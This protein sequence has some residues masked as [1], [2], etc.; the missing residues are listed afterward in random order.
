MG[1]RSL[2]T[3]NLGFII[4]RKAEIHPKRIAI[5]DLTKGETY[6]YHQ[7]KERSDLCACYLLA[8]GLKRGDTV[9]GLLANRIECFDLMFACAKVGGIFIPLNFRMS[10]REVNQILSKAKSPVLFYDG[11]FRERI[12]EI[13]CRNRKVI[14]ID[15]TDLRTNIPEKPVYDYGKAEDPFVLIYTSGTSGEPKGAIQ[16]HLNAFFKSVDSIIDFGM[17]YNDVVLV[18]APMF[19]VAGLNALTLPGLHVGGR[20]VLHGRFEAEQALQIIEDEQVTCFA[21]VPTILRMMANAPSFPKRKFRSLRFAM[22]GG[23]FLE[24]ELQQAF[25]EKGADILN[26]FGLSETTDG[27]IY[28]R[29]GRPPIEACIGNVGTHVDVKLMS[30]DFQEVP[31]GETGEIVVGGPTVSPGYWKDPRRTK[32]T[33]RNGWVRTGDLAY[34]DKEGYFYTVGRQDEMIK[35]GAEKIA[36]DEIERVI[37]SIPKV[38]DAVVI[39]IPDERWGQVPKA[40]VARKRGMELTEEEII[41]VCKR[42]L[43]SYKK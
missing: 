35:S 24:P 3:A 36:P 6:S 10:P 18:T 30:S 9:S 20:L 11:T 39:G 16:T 28:Q 31:E 1:T 19:H 5:T 40:I 26:T 22:A 41:T 23:E 42:E 4:D 32:E 14:D 25:L 37:C 29:P 8:Q 17:T 38:A 15:T 27:A 34:K 21:V 2:Y 7:L 12:H 33:F 13:D 43:A